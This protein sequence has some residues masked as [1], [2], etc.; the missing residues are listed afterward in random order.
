VCPSNARAVMEVKISSERLRVCLL[1]VLAVWAAGCNDSQVGVVPA[2]GSA[3]VMTT[4][5][6]S[7]SGSSAVTVAGTGTTGT[8]GVAGISLPAAG[9]GV[10]GQAAATGGTVAGTGGGAAGVGGASGTAGS[11][12]S[13]NAPGT[14]FPMRNLLLG[15]CV[16]MRAVADPTMCTGWDELYECAAQNCDLDACEK[17]CADYAAC[18]G[19]AP[20]ACNVEATCPKSEECD[21]CSYTAL[22]CAIDPCALLVRCATPSADG[23]CNKLSAYCQ[24]QMDPTSCLAYLD[25]V[26]Q[27]LG[28]EGCQALIDDQ[29]AL[30]TYFNDPPC[31]F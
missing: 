11:G 21:A 12:A 8:A 29:S 24:T 6:T 18:A 31:Q 15:G 23:P 22:Q 26:A 25:R 17:T 3:S 14:V 10:A 9:V 19:A 30:D 20:D 13:P 27:L 1:C 4:A 16:L 28:D 7:T 2:A 5:G